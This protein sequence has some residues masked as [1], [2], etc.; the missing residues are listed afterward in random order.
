MIQSIAF[1]VYPISDMKRARDF[2]ERVLG[3]KAGSSFGDE[4][5]EYDVGGATFAITAMDATHKPAAKGAVVAFEVD[6][7]DATVAQL[8]AAGARFAQENAES[9]VCRFA[10]ALDPDGNELI[11]HKRK[12]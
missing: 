3:L 11:I 7:L 10:I 4:W 8:K 5:I 12:S 1:F 2:Y 6:D 9:P